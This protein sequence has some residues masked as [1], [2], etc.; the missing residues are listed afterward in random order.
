MQVG[1]SQLAFPFEIII[2]GKKQIFSSLTSQKIFCTLLDGAI[3]VNTF[4]K[5]NK[6]LC[7]LRAPLLSFCVHNRNWNR[8]FKCI[9]RERFGLT[10]VLFQ[11]LASGSFMYLAVYEKSEALLC[12][13]CTG[14]YP[15]FYCLLR[16]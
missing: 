2:L 9:R 6:F 15:R 5:L 1:W 12:A 13:I 10:K 4:I 8:T 14:H 7:I 16:G 3:R 11:S